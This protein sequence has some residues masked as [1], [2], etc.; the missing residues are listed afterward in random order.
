MPMQV[1][2]GKDDMAKINFQTVGKTLALLTITGSLVMVGGCEALT[3][4]SGHKK[5][6]SGAE[7]RWN[8]MRSSSMLKLAQQQFDTG[9]LEQS[10][11]T[12]V[13]A[14]SVDA[15]SPA[16]HV[17]SGRIAVER[18]QLERAR[19]RFQFALDLDPKQVSALYYQGVV[20]QRWQQ[21]DKA[22]AV[23]QQAYDLQADN[24]SFLL[25][26]SE[27]LVSMN[28]RNEAI[29]LLETKVI[30]FDQNAS[31][32]SALG[33]LYYMNQDFTN[34][35]KYLKQAS[36]LSP[37]NKMMLENLASAFVAAESYT[38]AIVLLEQL[39]KDP[40]NQGRPGLK[41]LLATAYER[42]NQLEEAARVYIQLTRSDRRD[43]EAWYKLASISLVRDDTAG[44]LT[45]AQR[46]MALDGSRSEGFLIAAVVMQRRGQLD[47]AIRL[48]DR[49]AA[50][51]P[52][53]AE[54]VLL[55][56]I[57]LERAGNKTAAASAYAEALRRSPD[58]ARAKNLLNRL[59]QVDTH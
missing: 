7:G 5:A 39:S 56:G 2:Q 58:D 4:K 20:Y 3:P 30:Y 21:Y 9:D 54:P 57:A 38:D 22:Y 27:M 45:A 52:T 19:D 47:Q 49:A 25:A 10:E 32:R 12:L 59:S 42:D 44:A 26:M 31:I 8:T 43:V 28:K 15:S 55:Q 11:K 23:Y 1:L 46:V 13:E 53:S 34:A 16:L 29:T 40:E 50:L 6:M 24:I 18:G 41:R 37:D 17:L 35:V 48:F 36:Y 14:M 33:Q 51:A